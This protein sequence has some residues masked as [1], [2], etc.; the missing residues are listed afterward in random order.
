MQ[1][2]FYSRFNAV[3]YYS[4]NVLSNE[5]NFGVTEISFYEEVYVTQFSEKKK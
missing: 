3:V 2:Y 1:K 5:L 4:K